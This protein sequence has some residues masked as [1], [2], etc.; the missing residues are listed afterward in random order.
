MSELG[1]AQSAFKNAIKLYKDNNLNEAVEQ[2]EEIIKIEPSHKDSSD[3]LVF[4]YIKLNKPH[5][6]LKLVNISIKNNSDNQEYYE[7][8]YKLLLYIGEHNKALDCL[9]YLH[10]KYPSIN[11]VR[12]ISNLYI[13][14]NDIEKSENVIQ[15]F[16]ESNQTYSDLYK[17]IRHVK[18]GRNKLAEESYKK[19]LKQLNLRK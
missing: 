4:L 14:K 15:K 5:L 18:A 17:G 19:V 7:K 11:T 6:A 8:K 10:N 13:E 9:E 12:E 1:N 16:F 3:F 2:L